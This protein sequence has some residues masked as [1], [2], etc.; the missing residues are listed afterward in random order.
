MP[1]WY[2]HR[3]ARPTWEHRVTG[4]DFSP[5]ALRVARRLA[6]DCETPIRFVES[7]LYD[8]PAAL[9]TGRFDVVYTGI[10]ALCWLPDIKRW[11]SVVS[12]LLSPGGQTVHP[13][14]PPS[15][16]GDGRGKAPTAWWLLNIPISKSAGV[17]TEEHR[18]YV[19][20][21]GRTE[22]APRASISTM[23][24]PR[25]LLPSMRSGMELQS[26]KST[27]R[28]RGG[29]WSLMETV[30]D[31]EFRLMTGPQRLAASYTLQAVK[32]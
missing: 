19:D 13:R 1:Y 11:A 24:S 29:A 32:H 18:T 14:R 28:C 2:R 26:S 3:V 31:G 30:G 22:F 9:G 8:A 6:L 20:H 17:R 4:L 10:G 21:R 25:S 7:E 16:V 12:S 15:V 23:G 5:S 27:I